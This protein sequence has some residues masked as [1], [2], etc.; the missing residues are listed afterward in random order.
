VDTKPVILHPK[1]VDQIDEASRW[2]RDRS[3]V[4]G[5]AFDLALEQVLNLIRLAP[6]AGPL[7]QDELRRQRVKGFPYWV[8]YRVDQECTL[9]LAIH[10]ER[11]NQ[12]QV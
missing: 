7:I 11:R 12:P 3:P 4:A 5:Y 1:A 6:Q 9:V 8:V 10:H 2:Y